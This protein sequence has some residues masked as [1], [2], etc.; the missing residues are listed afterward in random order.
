M[1]GTF[2]ARPVSPNNLENLER[3][4]LKF[5]AKK[6]ATLKEDIP[7]F[8]KLADQQQRLQAEAIKEDKAT[9][10]RLFVYLCHCELF[11]IAKEPVQATDQQLGLLYSLS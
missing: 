7:H 3:P 8:A 11:T 2:R 5:K 4:W 10:T 1:S 9:R 6:R